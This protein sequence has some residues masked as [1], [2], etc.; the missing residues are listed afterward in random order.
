MKLP[1]TKYQGAGND[2]I[3][4]DNRQR[5][6]DKLDVAALCH[7]KFG[8]GGDG[9]MLLQNCD[10]FDFEMVYY[11]SD[12]NISSM[13]GNGGRCIV[14]FAGRLGVY[15]GETTLFKAVDGPHQAHRTEAYVELQMKDVDSVERRDN[16]FVLNTGSPHYVL[17]A[18]NIDELDIIQAARAIR[19]NHEFAKAG[20]N[21]NFVELI[22][23]N[24][25]KVRTYERGVE[26]ETLSCGT[27]VTASAIALS[28][29]LNLPAG[30]KVINIETP[31]GKLKV[32]YQKNNSAVNV[33]LCG[34]ATLVFEGSIDI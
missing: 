30:D 33:W 24:S 2:F 10:G 7:P 6:Y 26:N 29:Y 4:I 21:V 27:G 20:I 3:I 25:I 14:D 31:G 17:F 1:F 32:K 28:E 16:A 15:K 12:G 34:P 18:Q 5:L 23:D 11:N 22:S 9:L 19:Y 13:C 8:I